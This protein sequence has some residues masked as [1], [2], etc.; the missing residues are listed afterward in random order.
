MFN[1]TCLINTLLEL[2]LELVTL[3]ELSLGMEVAE[4]KVTRPY[5]STPGLEVKYSMAP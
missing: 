2:N 1:R 4:R 5:C 3:P